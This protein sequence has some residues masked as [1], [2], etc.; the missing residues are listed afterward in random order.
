MV[1]EYNSISH[2]IILNNLSQSESEV[3][4]LCPTLCDPMDSNLQGSTVHRIFQAR[5]LEWA[6][7]SFSRGSSQPLAKLTPY[8]R[9]C[10]FL[11]HCFVYNHGNANE[12]D[13]HY[14][15]FIDEETEA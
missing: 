1:F 8:V 7:I 6:A 2:L 10:A 3:A 4:Q 13:A 12:V 15:H 14:L 9:H 11:M 5:I